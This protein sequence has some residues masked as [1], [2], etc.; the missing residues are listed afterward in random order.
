MYSYRIWNG[1][2]L[3]PFELRR[4]WHLPMALDLEAMREA[5]QAL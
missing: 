3:S 5:A 1:A 4:A 2:V